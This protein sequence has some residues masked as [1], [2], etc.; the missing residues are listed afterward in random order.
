MSVGAKRK[1]GRAA[2]AGGRHERV[3]LCLKAA[4]DRYHSRDK[5]MPGEMAGDV[6][7]WLRSVT[8]HRWFR[9][10]NE[11]VDLGPWGSK[12]SRVAQRMRRFS[13]GVPTDRGMLDRFWLVPVPNDQDGASHRHDR[14]NVVVGKTG[15]VRVDH[16]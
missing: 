16:R 2:V 15:Q 5:A 1:H 14:Q 8:L 13:S 11:D 10:E 6:G 7:A 3:A 12:C 4:A 9:V